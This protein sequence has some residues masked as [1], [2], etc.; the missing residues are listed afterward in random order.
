MSVRTLPPWDASM[1]DGCSGAPLLS[2]IPAARA[3]CVVHDEA[4]YYGGSAT[5]RLVADVRFR[6]CLMAHGIPW[7]RAT[8]ALI[9]IRLFGG[10]GSKVPRVSWGFGGS[11]F[12]YTDRPAVAMLPGATESFHGT[13]P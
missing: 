8:G 7:W 11:V 4:Y 13:L 1:S 6:A 12:A 3:C 5:D 9:A 2:G 10:P